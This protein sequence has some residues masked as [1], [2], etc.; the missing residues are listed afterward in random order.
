MK[1]HGKV[2]IVGAGPGDWQLISVKGL[3][4]VKKADCILYDFLANKK[5]L[6]FAKKTTKKICVGKADGLRLKEQSQINQMLYDNSLLYKNVVR[7]KGGDP[8]VFSRGFEEFKYLLKRGI[9]AEVISGIPSAIAG[10]ASFKIPLTV[11]DKF[12]SFAVITGRKKDP[13]AK[14]DAPNCDTLVYLMGVGNIKNIVKALLNSGRSKSMACAFIQNATT[15]KARIVKATLK[16][17]ESQVKYKKV[18]PPAIFIVGDIIK[19]SE[20]IYEEVKN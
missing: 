13:K 7:L 14:I 8:F 9:K 19:Y 12:Q 2:Y 16:T 11:K 10:P 4:I 18:K 20:N 6:Q 17:I 5:L 15:K 3:D 1:K